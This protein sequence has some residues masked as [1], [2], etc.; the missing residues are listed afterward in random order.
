[1]GRS[2]IPTTFLAIALISVKNISIFLYQL[3]KIG[4]SQQFWMLREAS[5]GNIR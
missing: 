3:K 4:L 1:M 5:V 2:K